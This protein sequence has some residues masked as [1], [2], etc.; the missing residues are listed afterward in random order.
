M[1]AQLLACSAL[2]LGG[3]QTLN[4]QETNTGIAAAED[5]GRL[6][7]IVVQAQRR[8]QALLDVPVSVTSYNA[9]ALEAKGVVDILDLNVANPSFYMNSLQERTGNSPVRIRGVGTVGSNPAFE[10]AVG[11][12]IDDVYRS[13][14]GMAL[15]TFLDIASVEVLRGPQGTLFGKNTVA[16]ALVLRSATPDLDEFSASVDLQ[17][18]NYDSQKYEGYINVPVAENVAIRLSGLIEKSDGFYRNPVTGEDNQPTDQSAIR[19][20]ISFEPNDRFSGRL[21]YDRNAA[22]GPYGYGRSTRIDNTDLDGSQNGFFG[23]AAL[24]LLPGIPGGLGTWYW[25]LGTVTATPPFSDAGRADPFSYEIGTN[26]LG[27]T[28]V[29]D[30]GVNLTLEY[31]LTDNISIKSITSYREFSEDTFGADWDFGPVD[32]GGDLSLFYDFE[33]F[34]QEILLTG[35]FDFDNGQSL[36][37]VGG[38]HYFDEDWTHIRTG[39]GGSQLGPVFGIALDPTVNFAET[40]GCT[41]NPALGCFST[42]Q[43]AE[44]G[45]DYQDAFFTSAEQSFGIFGQLT[46]DLTEKISLIGGLRY[47]SIEKDGSFTR[48]LNRQPVD[49]ET[50]W[51]NVM[52]RALLFG[53]NG[54]AM[55]GRNFDETTK[56]EELTYNFAAQYRPTSSSQ[57]YASYSRGFKA[58]GVNLE[59]AAAGGAPALAGVPTDLGG[60]V[61]LPFTPETPENTTF[62]PEFVDAYEIGFRLEYGGIGRVSLAGFRSEYEDLQLTIFTGTEF[63]VFNTGS[64]TVQGLELENTTAVTDNLTIDVAA[65][66]LETAEFGGDIDP[67]LA[68][69]RRRG[70]APVWALSLGGQY[71]H[72]LTNELDA[73][74]NLNYSY[75]GEHFLSDE[76]AALA[77][78]TQDAYHIVNASIGLRDNGNWDVQLFCTNCFGEDYFGYA[79]NQP[80]IAGGSAMANPAA[81]GVYGVS[82]RK[83]F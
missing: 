70:Q 52:T 33:T 15:S 2:A 42:S 28:R 66:W 4:A 69:G 35:D 26:Q 76:G 74:A 53:F 36:S 32:F 25:E 49:R 16:G 75:T 10:G 23:P 45:F 46:Y 8:D 57:L 34:S 59:V 83:E 14:S 48:R 65:T 81:P 17:F 7:T 73:Y 38:A 80:F 64:S 6:E 19:A 47:N 40:D 22:D 68:A 31:D 43:L 60:G 9:E 72:P 62:A 24:N 41:F 13:R 63:Q 77:D 78:V 18:A 67:R 71:Y 58:G 79:F 12:Y 50:Y 51:N 44:E 3:V 21:I 1:K 55:M 20:Q 56:D 61:V 11:I 54:A 27:N 5:E 29:R 82:L 37:F 30:Q 39:H